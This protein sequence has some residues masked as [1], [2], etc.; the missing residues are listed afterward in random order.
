M[1]L[2]SYVVTLTRSD[3]ILK[4]CHA[5]IG[6]FKPRPGSSQRNSNYFYQRK[7]QTVIFWDRFFE[8]RREIK[9]LCSLLVNWQAFRTFLSFFFTPQRILFVNFH[10]FFSLS[11]H[12]FIFYFY[13]LFIFI[14]M[15]EVVLICNLFYIS[16]FFMIHYKTKF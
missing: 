13:R 16:V 9:G 1:Q 11:L 15:Y 10:K 6:Q 5:L 3:A 8:A 4:K 7:S 14:Y 12:K 2:E